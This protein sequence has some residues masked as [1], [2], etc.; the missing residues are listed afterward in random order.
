MKSGFINAVVAGGG[1]KA[2]VRNVRFFM[3]NL[4]EEKEMRLMRFLPREVLWILSP[5]PILLTL[6][7]EAMGLF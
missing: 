5:E 4:A 7:T 6:T 1:G 2:A 3:D